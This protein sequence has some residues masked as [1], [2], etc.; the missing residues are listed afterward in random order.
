MYE[1]LEVGGLDH[2]HAPLNELYLEDDYRE[3]MRMGLLADWTG[4]SGALG[5]G[6][7]SDQAMGVFSGNDFIAFRISMSND[8][9]DKI[10]KHKA[11]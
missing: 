2:G 6:Q 11:E 1:L 7:A 9:S 10:E 4:K 3:S 5:S 8:G